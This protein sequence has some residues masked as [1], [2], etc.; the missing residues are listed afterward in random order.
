[1]IGHI[2]RGQKGQISLEVEFQIMCRRNE[3]TRKS[4]GEQQTDKLQA[5]S[6]DAELSQWA[7]L[8]RKRNFALLQSI[9]PR[10]L[11]IIAVVSSYVQE[12]SRKPLCG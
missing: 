11:L 12:F 1:M 9:S 5:G 2:N 10:Y 3:R 8:G 4:P 7:N 6:T